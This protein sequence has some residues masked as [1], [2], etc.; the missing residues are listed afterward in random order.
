MRS[1]RPISLLIGAIV[2]ST[3]FCSVAWAQEL[4]PNNTCFGAQDGGALVPPA[5]VSGTIDFANASPFSDVDFY[6]FT[7]APGLALTTAVGFNQRVGL[8]DDA[9]VLQAASDPFS[10]VE[11]QIEFTVPERGTF[12]LAVADRFDNGFNGFGSSFSFA[13]YQLSI[14]LQ[15]PPIGSISGRLVDAVSRTPLVGATTPFARVELRRCSNGSCSEVVN[16]QNADS[17]G[18]FRFELDSRGRRIR[19]GDFQLTASAEE[20]QQATLMFSVDANQNVDVGDVALIPPPI[21]F[22]N[23]RPCTAILP[24]GGVCQYS[25]SIRN[26]TTARFTGQALSQVIGGLGST[27]FE[28][29]TQRSGASPVR[30]PV[31]VPALGSRDVTFFF[32]VPSFV[33]NGTTVCT[34][35]QL[36]LD[37][38]PLFNVARQRDLFCIAKG[39]SGFWVMSPAESRAVFDLM[40]GTDALPAQPLK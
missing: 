32:N 36:G 34:Q 38:S 40:K 10:S 16:S 21:L 8:F 1:K 9:C 12:I 31:S 13:P 11:N 14:T 23:V 3:V 37:P 22:S 4:E 35:L 39:G 26:N 6:R 27:R 33:P 5:F 18:R 30:T 25:V 29:S 17:A 24:Q 28:A 19:V 20:F 2:W 7:A 15:P